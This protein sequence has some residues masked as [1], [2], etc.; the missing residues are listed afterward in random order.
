MIALRTNGTQV[1][2]AQKLERP[3]SG[4]VKWDLHVLSP[5]ESGRLRYTPK[6]EK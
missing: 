5:D 4:G 3:G 1:L 2:F 6:H